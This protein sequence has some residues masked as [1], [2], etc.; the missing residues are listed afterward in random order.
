MSNGRSQN[1]MK[2]ALFYTF[3]AIFAATAAVTLL[4]IT[5]VVAIDDFYLKGLFGALLI[6]LVGAVIALYRATPFFQAKP[7]KV[8]LT[9]RIDQPRGHE[10]VER[11]FDCSGSATGIEPDVAF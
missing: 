4:G 5:G 9:A 7:D 8:P 2:N 6:E 3:L 10:T 1:T 11:T